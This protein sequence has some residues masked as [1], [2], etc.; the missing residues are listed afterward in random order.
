[1]CKCKIGN[2]RLLMLDQN[3]KEFITTFIDEKKIDKFNNNEAIIRSKK[4][5]ETFNFKAYATAMNE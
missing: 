3:L 4:I 2:K 1:M 5:S